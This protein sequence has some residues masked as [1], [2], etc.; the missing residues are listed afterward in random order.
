M[1]F[2]NVTNLFADPDFD[3]DPVMI[4]QASEND[5]LTGAEDETNNETIIDELDG[6]EI[7]FQKLLVG[8]IEDDTK[9]AKVLPM[10]LK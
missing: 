5:D 3:G 8:E 10:E 4:K 6:E 2:R 7:K 1:D 9:L